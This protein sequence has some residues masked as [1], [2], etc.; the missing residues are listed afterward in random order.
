[1]EA[2]LSRCSQEPVELTY[3]GIG[4][5]PHVPKGGRL[6]PKYDQIFPSCFH[7]RVAVDKRPMRLVHFDP[8]FS[9]CKE[10]LDEYFAELKMAPYE[11]EGGYA[12][13]GDC[14]EAL[15]VPAMLD[16]K[17]HLWFFESLVDILLETK[18]KFI[19]QEYTGYSLNELNQSLYERCPQKE[20]YKRRIL[21][22]MTFGTDLGCCTD[23]TKIQ[24]F[25]DYSS[26][27]LNLHFMEQKELLRWIEVSPG[28]DKIIKQR[29]KTEFLQTL[30]QMHV[31]YRRKLRGEPPLSL[32]P[33]YDEHTS[34]ERLMEILQDSLRKPFAVLMALHVVSSEA[35][36]SLEEAFAS[37]KGK[38]PYKWYDS[39]YKLVCSV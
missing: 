3:L 34:S 23:M 4:S 31:D 27:F 30:N 10:F 20:L 15:F 1:M 11:F 19:L 21:L 22:D 24:P 9:N 25:Y 37:Y 28:L 29:A 12:Y 32:S 14:C 8:Q 13:V 18:G 39:V 35:K 5:C 17:E 26:N 38:D 6:E 36:S 16:H 2:I 33:L 7:Q